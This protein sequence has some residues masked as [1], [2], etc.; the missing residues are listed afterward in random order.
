LHKG[1]CISTS[2]GGY[3]QLRLEAG[4]DRRNVAGEVVDNSLFAA[5]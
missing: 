2:L 5:R 4:H 3:G 1:H